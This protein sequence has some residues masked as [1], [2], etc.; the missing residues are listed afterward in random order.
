MTSNLFDLYIYSIV[1]SSKNA[2]D[3]AIKA[4]ERF[5]NDLRRDIG[6]ENF[7]RLFAIHP[8]TFQRQ[9]AS[10]SISQGKRFRFFSPHL[11]SASKDDGRILTKVKNFFRRLYRLI[12]WIFIGTIFSDKNIHQPTYDVSDKG[13]NVKDVNSFRDASYAIGKEELRRKKRMI[14]QA[15]ARR[16]I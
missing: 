13:V 15:L 10:D 1:Y 7:S 4:T 14:R 12:K 11:A 2:V 16:S 5:F 6:D 9:L 8:T 3:L